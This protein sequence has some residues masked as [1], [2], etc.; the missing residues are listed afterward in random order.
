[1]FENF[2]TQQ[3]PARFSLFPENHDAADPAQFNGVWSPW[4]ELTVHSPDVL[5]VEETVTVHSQRIDVLQ[6]LL[7]PFVLLVI[8]GVCILILKAIGQS[9]KEDGKT[10]C[11]DAEYGSM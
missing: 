1:M 11:V 5:T 7:L 3:A 4:H 9:A 10:K 8:G 6:H 2:W